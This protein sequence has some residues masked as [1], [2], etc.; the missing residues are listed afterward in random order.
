MTARKRSKTKRKRQ[1]FTLS[2][3]RKLDILGIAMLAVAGFTTLSLLSINRGAVTGAWLRLLHLAFGWGVFL[4]P[5]VL[6]AFGLWLLV[7]NFGEQPLFHWERPLGAGILFLV[8]L[9]VLHFATPS[10]DPSRL[11][12]E[13]KGGGYL[14]WAISQGLKASIG[15]WGAYIALLALTGVAVIMLFNISLWQLG[16]ALATGW[17]NV[18]QL[19][20]G[21]R[22]D[23]KIMSPP[24]KEEGRP[25]RLVDKIKERVSAEA[26]QRPAPRPPDRVVPRIIGAPRR[27]WQLPPWQE[28]LEENIEQELE[29]AEI[30][31]KVKII[32]D[33]LASFG[34][35]VRVVEVSQGPTVTQFGVEPGYVEQRLSSGKVRRSKVK[36]SKINALANDLALAL[37]AS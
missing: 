3:D 10:V 22:P 37:A 11:A 33:T 12:Y 27:Q 26:V 5:V 2:L 14:G 29:Q 1:G 4:L 25:A 6:A 21:R 36:V 20:R 9:A 15:L 8:G 31:E 34:V 28:I 24:G 30:R 32:E 18:V 16:K 13:G 7:R 35:P 23:F 19:Y 17:H